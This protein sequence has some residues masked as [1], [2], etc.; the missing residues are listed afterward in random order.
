MF[1]CNSF[2]C[3]LDR[4]LHIRAVSHA[5]ESL[6]CGL[7]GAPINN[8]DERALDQYGELLP[9]IFAKWSGTKSFNVIVPFMSMIVSTEIVCIIGTVV[10]TKLF[11]SPVFL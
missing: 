6:V 11:R 1:A 9:S 7:D 5:L 2:V 10:G 8:S 4:R 3:D